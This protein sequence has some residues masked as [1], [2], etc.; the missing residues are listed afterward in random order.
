MYEKLFTHVGLSLDRLRSFSEIVAAGGISAAA[1]KDPNRQSQLSRQL[2]ELER[3]F[4][5]ELLVRGRGR[6]KLTPA[7]S[8]LHR[9]VG[10]AFGALEKFSQSCA[11][12]PVE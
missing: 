5:V 7:G 6:L 11:N 3:Y 12:Q 2:K 9:I 10:Q 1:G 4:G 8:E